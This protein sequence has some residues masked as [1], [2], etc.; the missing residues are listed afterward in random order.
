MIGLKTSG[1]DLAAF[2]RTAAAAGQEGA[3]KAPKRA[4]ANASAEL[5]K[6]IKSRF[7][8]VSYW[9]APGFAKAIRWKEIAPGWWRTYSRAVYVKGR[10]EPVDLLWFFDQPQK[11]VSSGMGKTGV[12][13]PLPDSPLAH[14]GRRYAWPSEL[15][16]DGWQL[17]FLPTRNPAVT[18]ILGRIGRG[19]PKPLFLWM[20]Q[21]RPRARLD[22]ES[23]FAKHA[24]TLDDLW[25]AYVDEALEGR[26]RRQSR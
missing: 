18:L 14:S 13:V 20:K 24:A 4:A 19:Q 7:G 26:G 16:R 11:T 25:A 22:L 1:D 2:V 8:R 12:A 9:N 6:Q 5:K 10:S 17:E 3:K 21:T 15:I 23:L